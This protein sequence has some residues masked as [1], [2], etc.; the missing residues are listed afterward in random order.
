MLFDIVT[1]KI[2]IFVIPVDKFS[3]KERAAH[4]ALGQI[5]VDQEETPVYS[6]R[7]ILYT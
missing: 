4:I 5:T 1:V 3:N 7:L 2:E 6:L